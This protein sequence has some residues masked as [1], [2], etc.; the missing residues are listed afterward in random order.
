MRIAKFLSFSITALI[1]LCIMLLQFMAANATDTITIS[2]PSID[3]EANVVTAY[4]A[5]L[6][7]GRTWDLRQLGS[8]VARLDSTGQIGQTGN[9]VLA[10]HSELSNRRQSVFY[11]LGNVQTGSEISVNMN[12]V[13]YRY[14]VIGIQNIPITELSVLYPTSDERLTLLTCDPAS[15]EASTGIYTRRIAVTAMRSA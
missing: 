7:E 12:G 13:E 4:I 8:S 14:T 5:R 15:Y 11:N 1:T 10:G 3:V 9:T 6:P 2:I